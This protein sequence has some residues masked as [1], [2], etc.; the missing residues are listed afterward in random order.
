MRFK[1]LLRF[2]KENYKDVD[3]VLN[4]LEMVLNT[5]VCS[6]YIIDILRYRL[7]E[8]YWEV[9]LSDEVTLMLRVPL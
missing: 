5:I 2:Y 7:I 6:S 8:D 3:R 9:G 1:T 4:R